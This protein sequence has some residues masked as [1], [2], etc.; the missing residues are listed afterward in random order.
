MTP[1]LYNIIL[2]EGSGILR[3]S[4]AHWLVDYILDFTHG[5]FAV[6]T[7]RLPVIFP[8]RLCGPALHVVR[9]ADKQI[10]CFC[11]FPQNVLRR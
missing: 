1:F 5:E 2:E 10:Y 6:M 11:F 4:V 3:F 9:W 8:K 7:C